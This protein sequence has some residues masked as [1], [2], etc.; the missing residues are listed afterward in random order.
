MLV[1]H[2]SYCIIENPDITFSREKV[3][4]GKG[5][6]VTPLKSQAERWCEKFIRKGQTAY[7]NVY[8]FDESALNDTLIRLKKFTSYDSEWL[9]YVFACRKGENIYKQYDIVIGGIANDR[10]FATIDAYFSGYMSK[11]MALDKL[12]FERPNAQICILS[13]DVLQRILKFKESIPQ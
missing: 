2:G 8:E 13:Q 11:E 7:L 10:I 6:Y 9:D 12:R 4:F 5:F 1:Y 3:D